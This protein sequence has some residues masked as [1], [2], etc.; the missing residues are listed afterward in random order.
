M[1]RAPLLLR[2]VQLGLIA[3]VLVALLTV[4]AA[5]ALRGGLVPQFRQIVGV[6]RGTALVVENGLF[7]VP[8]VPLAACHTRARHELRIWVYAGGAKHEL[9]T[10]VPRL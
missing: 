6:G 5:G 3:V 10:Y 9:L 1:S 8:D 4:G 7:C 2:A